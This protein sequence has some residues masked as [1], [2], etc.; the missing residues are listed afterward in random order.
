VG[1]VAAEPPLTPHDPPAATTWQ[2]P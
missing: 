1:P 2:R